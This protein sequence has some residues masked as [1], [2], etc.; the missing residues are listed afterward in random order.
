MSIVGPSC[1]SLSPCVAFTLTRGVACQQLAHAAVHLYH[2][3]IQA[4]QRTG[5]VC[6]VWVVDGWLVCWRK[7]FQGCAGQHSVSG[8]DRQAP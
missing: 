6:V 1:L 7:Q 2:A 5:T 8:C 4:L 3:L